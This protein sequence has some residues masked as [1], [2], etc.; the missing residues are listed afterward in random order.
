MIAEAHPEA[1]ALGLDVL[2]QRVQFVVAVEVDRASSHNGEGVVPPLRVNWS[3][4]PLSVDPCPHLLE[5]AKVDL[6]IEIGRKVSAV[7][8]GI[9]IHDVYC[10]DLVEV[11]LDGECSPGI[12]H[13][14]IES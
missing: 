12:D 2:G 9:H 3:L 1:D 14:G 7:T 13:T 4:H 8:S 6:G 11:A 10:I 5:F